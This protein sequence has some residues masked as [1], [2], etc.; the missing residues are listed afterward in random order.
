MLAAR[1]EYEQIMLPESEAHTKKR[2]EEVQRDARRIFGGQQDQPLLHILGGLSLSHVFVTLPAMHASKTRCTKIFYLLEHLVAILDAD[3]RAKAGT[4]GKAKDVLRGRCCEPA[5]GSGWRSNSVHAIW[6]RI[7]GKQQEIYADILEARHR[8]L[9]QLVALEIYLLYRKTYAT[10]YVERLLELTHA[11]VLLVLVPWALTAIY[12]H[13]LDTD[14]ACKIE[15]KQEKVHFLGLNLLART[16]RK[17][18]QLSPYQVANEEGTERLCY[19]FKSWKRKFSNHSKGLWAYQKMESRAAGKAASPYSPREE[20]HGFDSFE[21]PTQIFISFCF[22]TALEGNKRQASPEGTSRIAEWHAIKRELENEENGV[23]VVAQARGFLITTDWGRA[24]E[25][26]RTFHLTACC[27]DAQCSCPRPLTALPDVTAAQ[28]S[29]LCGKCAVPSP[30]E[31]LSDEMVDAGPTGV[32]AMHLYGNRLHRGLD[33]PAFAR[34]ATHIPAIDM[35]LLNPEHEME[36]DDDSGE[37]SDAT[38][39]EEEVYT[40]Q[41]AI[42]MAKQRQVTHTYITHGGP[43]PSRRDKVEHPQHGPLRRTYYGCGPTCSHTN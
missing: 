29:G 4:K 5:R 3:G 11:R 37:D 31:P 22:L 27:G 17:F 15:K 21:L 23:A 41:E 39:D 35:S 43:G 38:D 33:V 18:P 14:E 16:L 12:R 26:I 13:L 36:L 32:I 25:G 9:P 34:G 42:A 40:M 20:H 8:L 30:I 7:F 1:T 2:I 19:A 28:G 24:Q 6:R 10:D